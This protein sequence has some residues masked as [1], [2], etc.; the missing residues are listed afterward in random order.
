MSS[1]SKSA[2]VY[3][4]NSEEQR[5]EVCTAGASETAKLQASYNTSVHY[6]PANSIKATV[7]NKYNRTGARTLQAHTASS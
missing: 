6:Q 1:W 2:N 7:I 3:N 4:H 5:C